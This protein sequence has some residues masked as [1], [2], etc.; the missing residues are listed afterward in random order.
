MI[1]KKYSLIKI[2]GNDIFQNGI[3]PL[4]LL[5][6]IIISSILIITI[7]HKTRILT[8]QKNLIIEERENLDI[9]WR[10][11]ILEKKSLENHIR[12]ER[13]SIEKLQ[14]I[15]VDPAQEHIVIIK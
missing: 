9:E 1:T 5:I 6:I 14:M 4:I 3:I 15:Y 7:T 12:I 8:S 13:F 10:N 2:I 11:L